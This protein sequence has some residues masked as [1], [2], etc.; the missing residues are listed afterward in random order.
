MQVAFGQAGD[1][2]F[3]LYNHNLAV[4]PLQCKPQM[5]RSGGS[6]DECEE[7]PAASG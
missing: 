4:H 7:A 3:T 6:E 2:V 5:K 1:E